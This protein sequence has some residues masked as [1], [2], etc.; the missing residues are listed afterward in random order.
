[1]PLYIVDK[2]L[3]LHILTQLRDKNTDQINFRKNMVRLGRI[4]GYEIANT[5]DYEIIEIETPLNVKTKGIDIVDL[6]NIV[7]INILRAAVPL[8][9]GLLK[10]F[11]KARQG[12]IAASR[13]EING[14]EVPK[15]MQVTIYYKKIP[16]IKAG[17]DNVIIADPMIAT[18]STM[19]KVLEEIVRANPKRIYIVS[20]I[21]SKYGI[22]RILSNYPS[23]YLF[24]V[25]IDPELNKK[26]YILPGLGDAGDRAFG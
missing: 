14:A 11:P 2:P 7:I 3:T 20:V 6:N 17:I 26:G 23:V 8:V 12:V 21:S 22:D 5:L 10:A 18:A 1:M 19:L 9:E 15:E 24:T 16:E 13:V 4:L 25:S